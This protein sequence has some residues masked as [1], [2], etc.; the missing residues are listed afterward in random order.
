MDFFQSSEHGGEIN[1]YQAQYGRVPLDFSVNVN[2]LGTPDRVRRAA[3]NALQHAEEYPDP[4]QKRLTDALAERERLQEWQILPGAGASDIIYRVIFSCRPSRAVITAPTFSE[5]ERALSAAGSA[6]SRFSLHEKEDFLLNGRMDELLALAE[7]DPSVPSESGGNQRAEMILL[8]EPNNPTGRTTDKK[9]LQYL[10]KECQKRQIILV[11]DESFIQLLDDPEAHT[12]IADGKTH[13]DLILLRS[14]TKLFAMP[15]IRLGC[16]I[17]F[18]KELREKAALC[19]PSWPVSGD[20]EA[21]GLAALE[22]TGYID[23]YRRQNIRERE[24]L[25]NE[26]TQISGITFVSRAEANY[27]LIHAETELAAPLAARG[28]LVRDCGNYHGL[29]RTWIRVC[30]KQHSDNIR[31][32]QAIRE[33]LRNPARPSGQKEAAQNEK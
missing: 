2:P 26:L 4:V 32:I 19:G 14:F 6:V 3:E 7:R 33:C 18:S 23:R 27:L 30:V 10:L 8:C 16:G 29:D 31:L 24:Y 13:P 1:R 5:Y 28:I 25:R 17:F 12:L 11:V 15:G 22:E 20:A 9:E 21:A